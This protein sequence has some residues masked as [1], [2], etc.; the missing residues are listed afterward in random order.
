MLILGP[1]THSMALRHF[2]PADAQKPPTPPVGAVG[3]RWLAVA[4]L[5]VLAHLQDLCHRPGTRRTV[6]ICLLLLGLVVQGVLL[7]VTAYLVDLAVSL[8]ELWAE[9]ARKHL[10]LTLS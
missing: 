1:H 6:H 2:R 4:V 5:W 8:M 10:E 3:G 9:L 7:F